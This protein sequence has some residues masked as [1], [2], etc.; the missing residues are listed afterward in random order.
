[1]LQPGYPIVVFPTFQMHLD[2][3]ERVL[4]GDLDGEAWRRAD[5]R[6]LGPLAGTT[7]A[8]AASLAGA[9]CLFQ[10]PQHLRSAWWN[11]LEKSVG[12]AFQP[13][14]S[15][16]ECRVRL[17][18]L[19]Y[20]RFVADVCRFLEF[21]EMP[22]PA[23]AV[24]D[25]LLSKPGQSRVRSSLSLSPQTWWGGVNLGDEATSLVFAN[26]PTPPKPGYPI[27]RLRIEPGEGFRLP[28]GIVCADI[29]TLDKHEPDLLLQIL[30]RQP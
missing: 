7:P 26:Q 17:E 29:C 25:L 4:L 1:M 20:E 18:S 11:V 2:L 21:K 22:V 5:N 23:G 6:E 28:V 19:T 3:A 30:T 9:V 13:D 27:V 12:Q 24:F 15:G 14:L 16:P 10:L 8:T